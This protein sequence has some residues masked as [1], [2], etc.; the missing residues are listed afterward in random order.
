M[1]FKPVLLLL[2]QPAP[3]RATP[4][5]DQPAARTLSTTGPNPLAGTWVASQWHTGARASIPLGTPVEFQ[6]TQ[7]GDQFSVDMFA[8]VGNALLQCGK[9]AVS[10][11]H[12]GLS[13]V[14]NETANPLCS[15]QTGVNTLNTRLYV[16]DTR[17]HMIVWGNGPSTGMD[18]DRTP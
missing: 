17:L 10:L 14:W 1:K 9:Q 6:I 5:S 7:H 12:H 8:N 11:T 16:I 15:K 13:N 2:R 18:F 3:S 4:V